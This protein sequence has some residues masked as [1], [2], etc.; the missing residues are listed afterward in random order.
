MFKEIIKSVSLCLCLV[1]AVAQSQS[2]QAQKT[3]AIGS[4]ALWQPGM[5]GM[6]DIKD[7]C[8]SAPDFGVCFAS[9]MRKEGASPQAVAFT[10]LTGNVGFMRDFRE[11]GR[12]DVA[13][14]NY[15]FRANENQSCLLVNGAPRVVDVDDTSFFSK[16][17]LAKN[18]QYAKLIKE[19]PNVAI[20]PGDR[21]G[22]DYP[23]AENLP[24][25][26]QRFVVSYR[27]LNGCHACERVGSVNYA[28]YFNSNGKFLGAKLQSAQAAIK[29]AQ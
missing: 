8:G 24:N 22:T 26:G 7:K 9:Q 28:F 16:T 6:Q 27:L 3:A 15:P 2:V 1:F 29:S 4:D 12:V 19:Y 11:T 10:K 20:F 18:P 23:I 5:Q 17:D 21:S 13:Y 14:V 25:G